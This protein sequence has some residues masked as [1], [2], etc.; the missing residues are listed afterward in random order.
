MATAAQIEANRQ[1]ALRS[2]GPR[3]PEGKARA[4]ANAISLGL[5]TTRDFVAE[6]DESEYG[7][8]VA[9]W[10]QHLQ[11]TGPAEETFAIEIIR[12]AWRLRRCAFIESNLEPG[13]PELDPMLDPATQLLQ[14]TVDRAHSSAQ[15]KLRR[16]I[17]ELRRIQTERHYREFVIP[18]N[19]DSA[20]GLADFR[21][22]DKSFARMDR[23]SDNQPS[24]VPDPENWLRSAENQNQPDP[25]P[26]DGDTI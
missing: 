6:G 20:L 4:A 3:T 9:V 7:Q 23:A 22:L 21:S 14:L 24:T 8:F 10:C 19:I 26:P 2:T 13:S 17:A 16:S 1:N 12:A 25:T 18:E 15:N 11:P 5:F